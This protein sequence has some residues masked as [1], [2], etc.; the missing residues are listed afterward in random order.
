M[1]QSIDGT[2]STNIS[3][4]IVT[5]VIRASTKER[6]GYGQDKA[7]RGFRC[8]VPETWIRP[9]DGMMPTVLALVCCPKCKAAK[10]IDS[11]VH[12]VTEKGEIKTLREHGEEGDFH[13]QCGLLRRVY[14][15]RWLKKPLYACA[16]EW[17][18]PDGTMRPEII[19]VNADSEGEAKFHCG[20]G[21]YRFV[22]V[23]LAIG[24]LKATAD[25]SDDN[26]L[27]ADVLSPLK[28]PNRG[29]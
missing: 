4:N 24:F 21:N 20:A 7:L 10:I 2:V 23:G 1:S 14:L 12:R 5:L 9:I 17:F 11:R 22:S 27:V 25:D 8:P 3:S 6:W 29:C 26:N 18:L 19:Y 28:H 15:D 16:V 13:C